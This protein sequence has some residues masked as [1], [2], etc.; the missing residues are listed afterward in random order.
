MS[1]SISRFVRRYAS[2][3]SLR[4]TVLLMSIFVASSYC[5]AVDPGL[6]E[7]HSF[8]VTDIKHDGHVSQDFFRVV[9]TEFRE[10]RTYTLTV[11]TPDGSVL[12]WSLSDTQ[13]WTILS[14]L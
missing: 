5:L 9:E 1:D 3:R 7:G 4:G 6:V 8:V 11:T 13:F 14:L 12:D 2:A 10:S